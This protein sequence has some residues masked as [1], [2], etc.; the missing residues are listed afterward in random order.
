MFDITVLKSEVTNHGYCL[1]DVYR[2][3]GDLNDS[4][5]IVPLE[6][7]NTFSRLPDARY[8]VNQPDY[9]EHTDY[10]AGYITEHFRRYD[11]RGHTYQETIIR[12]DDFIVASAN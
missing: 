7:N 11:Y 10:L 4:W 9:N 1:I 12:V 5:D 8:G 6:E 3:Q 2:A